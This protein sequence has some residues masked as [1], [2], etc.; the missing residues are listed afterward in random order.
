MVTI[1]GI[2]AQLLYVSPGQ[3][4]ALAPAG[5]ATGAQYQVQVN[6]NGALSAAETIDLLPV[7]AQ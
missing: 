4:N 6:V 2:P 7:T 5:L 1:G 3:V